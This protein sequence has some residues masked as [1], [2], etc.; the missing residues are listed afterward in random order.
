ML[1]PPVRIEIR[2]YKDA[3]CEWSKM[4]LSKI[5]LNHWLLQCHFAIQR[6]FDQ[7]IK[8]R[9]MDIKSRHQLWFFNSLAGRWCF[10]Y[11]LTTHC[12]TRKPLKIL[13]TSGEWTASPWRQCKQEIGKINHCDL[14]VKETVKVNNLLQSYSHLYFKI[15][16]RWTDTAFVGCRH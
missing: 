4:L 5:L 1:P 8:H 3:G 9:I 14:N 7:W 13:V 11:W 16:W 12:S 6:D 2:T 15:V 10:L